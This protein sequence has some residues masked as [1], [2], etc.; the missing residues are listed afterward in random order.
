M[1]ATEELA[2]RIGET[3]WSCEAL[4]VIRRGLNVPR[5]GCGGSGR[6]AIRD[7]IL[8]AAADVQ[9]ALRQ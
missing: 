9:C 1:V 3:A 4:G 7:S 6:R 5:S 2:E 8:L